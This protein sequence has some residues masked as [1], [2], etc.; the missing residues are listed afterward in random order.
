MLLGREAR[1]V[2]VG[3]QFPT[4]R[5][6]MTRRSVSTLLLGNTQLHLP[7]YCGDGVRLE[8][9]LLVFER[10]IRL[11]VFLFFSLYQAVGHPAHTPAL[12]RD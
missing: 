2:A 12:L 11:G 1:F 9:A 10:L 8:Q 7:G 6:G 4:R 3:H 5:S